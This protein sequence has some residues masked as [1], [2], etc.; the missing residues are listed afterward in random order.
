MTLS[1]T[2]QAGAA[3]RT[4]GVKPAVF[5]DGAAG[6]TGLG[7]RERLAR[8]SDVVVKQIA[9]DKRKDAGAKRALMQE[10]DLVI[11]CLPDDA[12]RETVALIDAMGAAGPKVLDASTAFRVAS[13]WTYGFPELAPDQADKIRAARQVSNPGC[14]PTGAVAL[15]RPLVDAGLVPADY[16]V[17]INA[18]SGYSGGGKAMIESFE[19]GSA[20]AFELYGLGFAHKH[21]PETQL[22]SNLTR[23][24]IF[25][26]SVGNFRQ[27]MLVSV[28]LHLDALPAKPHP[29]DLHAALAKRYAGSRYVSVAPMDGPITTSGRIEPE[30]LN[31]TNRLELFVFASAEH[32]QVVLVARLDNLGK[33]AS[34]AAVQNM[35]LMLGVAE[36]AANV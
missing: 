17:S 15:L 26:P 21:V 34:G 20:P 16:P 32:R 6:T 11:L 28:P 29:A 5:V 14:Y 2:N 35:R 24:P 19:N 8:Q 9:D 36:D 22:Y 10:V 12:A 31:E 7:I 3:T 13:G 18:V 4:S 30:A 25:V 27:G 1:D 33:G 23:R